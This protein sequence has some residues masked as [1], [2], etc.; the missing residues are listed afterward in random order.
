M[1]FERLARV[2]AMGLMVAALTSAR[3]AADSGPIRIG[4]IY[5]YSSNANSPLG[6]RLDAAVG[7]WMKEHGETIAGRKIELIRRDEGGVNPENAKRLAQGLAAFDIIGI[8][9]NTRRLPGQPSWKFLDV[10][11]TPDTAQYLS[12]AIAH[13]ARRRPE[14]R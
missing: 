12:G 11:F 4:V 13:G 2:A 1:S 8:A 6:P 9:G 5:A 3:S 10:R 7:A 14:R